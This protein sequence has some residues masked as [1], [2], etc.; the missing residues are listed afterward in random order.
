MTETQN[1]AAKAQYSF[2]E[3]H[4]SADIRI[5]HELRCGDL[6]RIITLH[7][8][9]YEPLDGFGLSFEAYV[10]KTISEYVLDNDSKGRVW[11]A[12]RENDL[13]GCVAIAEREENTAQLRWVLVDSAIRGFG[14]GQRLVALAL[15]H[16]IQRGMA[17]VCLET[18][19]GLPESMRLYEKLG[20]E[21]VSAETAELWDGSRK[22][23]KMTL[24]LSRASA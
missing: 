10:A 11:L 1:Q 22:L 14:L 2:S 3:P 19:D 17:A 20:F 23:I 13:V 12:E 21:V 6:G 4:D 5:R 7:G 15:D 9:A 24:Q 8:V 18:T 16:C